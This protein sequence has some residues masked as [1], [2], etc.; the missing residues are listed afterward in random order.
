[1]AK[2]TILVA[3]D[4]RV[5]VELLSLWLDPHGFT[6]AGAADGMQVIMAVRRAPPAAI[7]L[8]LMMPGGTGF[9]V[10]KRLH[11]NAAMQ[12][13]PVIV[14]SASVDPELPHTA[15]EAGAAAFLSKPLEQ[16]ELVATIRGV[17]GQQPGRPQENRWESRGSAMSSDVDSRDG[18]PPAPSSVA[19]IWAQSHD[20]IFERLAAVEKATNALRRATLTPEVRQK[21]VLE[22][23]RL[24]GSL[25]MFGLAQGTQVA[26]EIE[27]LLGD[28]AV[29]APETP[30]RLMELSAALRKELEKGPA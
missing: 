3:D 23:H 19:R 27:R 9:D 22:A 21:G 18:T 20:M 6:V 11:S 7:L 12:R 15:R 25:G 17:L 5:V 14:M 29:L 26:R 4:D 16:A 2:D 8:D 10:M 24:A 1:M 30:H 13:I 28:Q